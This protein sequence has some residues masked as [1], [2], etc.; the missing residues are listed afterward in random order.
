[1]PSDVAYTSSE[2]TF[3]FVFGFVFLLGCQF[4]FYESYQGYS[5]IC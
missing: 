3:C 5:S 1:M 2:D 4:C